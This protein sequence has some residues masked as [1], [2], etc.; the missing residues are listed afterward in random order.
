[1]SPLPPLAQSDLDE[2]LA[3]TAPL[4]EQMRGQSLFLTGGTGFF[5]TWL[6]ESFL[7][8]NRALTLNARVTVLTRNPAAFAAKAPHLAGNSAVTFLAGDI[9]SFKFPPGEFPFLLHAATEASAALVASNPAEML[10]TIVEGTQHVLRFAAQAGTRKLLLTSSGAVYGRQPSDLLHVPEDYLGAPDPLAPASV[11]GEGKRIAELLCCLAASPAFEVKIARCFAFLGPHLPL[12]THFAAGNFLADALAGRPIA[13]A[14]DGRA[15]RSYLYASDLA[16]WLW[17]LLF[18]APSARAYNV[19]SEHDVSIAQLAR[20]A[21]RTVAPELTVTIAGK[22]SNAP[23][24]RYVPSTRRAQDEL[25][26]RETV[27]LDEAL[28]RTLA[29]HRL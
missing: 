28:R 22:P 11:Y 23:P 15:L 27:S 5:G 14:G 2:I 17:T 20:A 7:H 12:D 1:M 13:I 8:A 18:Q 10:S 24:P 9:R 29:W 25:R 21:A 4:W 6:L 26:L 3:D 16:V 19:G